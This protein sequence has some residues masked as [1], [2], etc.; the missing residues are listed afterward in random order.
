MKILLLSA[1]DTDSHRHWCQGLMNQLS[2]FEWEYLAL[3]GRYFSWRIRGNPLSWGFGAER[4]R[5]LQH[6]DLVVATSMVDLATIKGLFPNLANTP[7]VCYFHENQFAYPRSRD[8]HNSIEP[9]MVTL[10]GALSAEAIWFNS[11]Y[12]RSTFLAGVEELIRQMPDQTPKGLAERLQ[13]K[14]QVIPVPI[15]IEC[16][17]S[18][19]RSPHNESPRPFNVIWNHRWEYDK[20]PDT[21]VEVI[22]QC[23]ELGL[24]IQFVIAGKRFRQIPKGFKELMDKPSQNL[25]HIGTFE[26]K[27]DYC[28]A[29]RTSDVVLS[30]AVHEFQGLAMLEGAGYGCV[31]LAPDDLAY[32][33]WIPE[34]LR[35]G[36][37]N[38][39]AACV[40]KLS[41][42]YHQGLPSTPNV[43]PFE[44][45]ILSE[46]YKKSLMEVSQKRV[47]E[48]C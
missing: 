19:T 35:Y 39:V 46:Q 7:C 42:W 45:R 20:G 9:Q 47:T 24:P 3:P 32:P 8:Q 30:T 48:L 11:E 41:H 21:L 4:S 43:A 6:Y 22:R 38:P 16:S 31:P 13:A 12:N 36:T 1:Y 17:E 37:D 25:I 40:E 28:H 33:E 23:E 18:E 14:S 44:W 26:N 10:Y 15:S 29:L 27:T 34:A 5:L 2:E